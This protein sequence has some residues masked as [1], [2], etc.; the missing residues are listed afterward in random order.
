MTEEK[1]ISGEVAICVSLKQT[2]RKTAEIYVVLTNK[3]LT[4]SVS[5]YYVLSI[6]APMLIAQIFWLMS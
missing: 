3:P 4:T 6:E 1:N 5:Y 2:Y